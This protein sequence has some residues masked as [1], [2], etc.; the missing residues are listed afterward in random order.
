MAV[1]V[2]AVLL[3][4]PACAPYALTSA[5]SAA[6]SGVSMSSGPGSEICVGEVS[7]RGLTNPS[8][9]TAIGAKAAG[10]GRQSPGSSTTF[11]VM[12]ALPRP[13]FCRSAMSASAA[14]SPTR[15]PCSIPTPLGM[16]ARD[17]A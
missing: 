11:R 17:V 7:A 1:S 6:Y 2:C 9:G 5:K 4:D 10:V 13:S 3:E 15:L 12:A 16:P 14:A 8:Q